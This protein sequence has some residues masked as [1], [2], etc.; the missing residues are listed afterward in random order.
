MKTKQLTLSLLMVGTLLLSGSLSSC[1]NKGPLTHSNVLISEVVEGSDFNQ[2]V[3]LYNM[4]DKDISLK[5]YSLGI[6]YNGEKTPKTTVE[7]EGTIKPQ[8][9]FII[10]HPKADEE[11]ISKSGQTSESLF[12]RGNQP[13]A[14][15]KGNKI[16][17]IVGYIGHTDAMIQD[18]SLVRKTSHFESR[19]EWDE[20]D[21][22]RYNEDNLKYLGNIDNSVTNI[23]MMEGPRID[24]K[25][26]EQS[27]IDETNDALG[28]GGFIDVTLYAGVDGDTAK[29]N[30]P[31]STGIQNGTKV[32]FQNINTPESY[33]ANVMPWG[34]PAKF[35][36]TEQ[37][38]QA[39]DIK[40]QSLDGGLL[41]DTFERLLG[42]VWVDGRLLNY[43]IVKN[44][45]SEIH[46]GTVDNML[47]K[48]I[49]YTSWLYDAQLQAKQKGKA[50]WGEKDPYWDYEKNE[51][52]YD[53]YFEI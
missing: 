37:L 4:S 48:D 42:W 11:I 26:F 1:G 9:T 33:T 31:A 53:G 29:F 7:L 40:L 13:I 51:S 20:Y 12:Y 8:S 50:I 2:A 52:T 35:W 15:M 46:F 5:G 30:Y 28:G 41:R 19:S 32:R 3:E 21:W 39:G 43:E 17:D 16:I 44:G 14:L 22:I 45:Y 47:Y 24:P 27:F 49:S 18:V 36:T 23:E 38:E 34:I 25:F 6:F 10:S